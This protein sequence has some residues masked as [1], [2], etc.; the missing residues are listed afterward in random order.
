MNDCTPPMWSTRL[1]MS[2]MLPSPASTLG[3][4]TALR[5]VSYEANKRRKVT[6]FG[7]TRR[8]T[9]TAPLTRAAAV[10]WPQ[11]DTP[12]N[13]L[14]TL[15]PEKF[16]GVHLL[17][18]VFGLL[19]RGRVAAAAPALPLPRL[20]RAHRAHTEISECGKAGRRTCEGAA[21]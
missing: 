15:W 10:L 13:A 11:L 3:L 2:K 8:Q 6:R 7:R 4:N 17:L 14:T 9:L 19:C 18:P 16:K 21:R 20:R 1:P 12:V 5:N